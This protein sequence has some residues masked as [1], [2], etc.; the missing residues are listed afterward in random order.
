MQQFYDNTAAHTRSVG[1]VDHRRATTLWA[2]IVGWYERSRQRKRLAEL[3][4]FL[5]RDIGISK[6]EAEREIAKP[7]WRP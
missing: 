1:P 2:L 3:D 6:R 7:F 5:L 4:E